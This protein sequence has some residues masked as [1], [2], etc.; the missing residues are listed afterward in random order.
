MHSAQADG[1]EKKTFRTL[2]E[3]VVASLEKVVEMS[4]AEGRGAFG[5]LLP[6]YLRSLTEDEFRP[7][8]LSSAMNVVLQFGAFKVGD[9]LVKLYKE[10]YPIPTDLKLL[11]LSKAD[12]TKDDEAVLATVVS[13]CSNSA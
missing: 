5:A 1:E 8:K 6:H 7:L 13:L 10:G 3:N 9:M 12:F 11:L 2:S 4:E